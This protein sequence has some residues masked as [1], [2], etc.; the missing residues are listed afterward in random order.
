MTIRAAQLLEH[1][2]GLA[3]RVHLHDSR[4]YRTHMVPFF[5]HPAGGRSSEPKPL[6]PGNT[7]ASRSCA[8]ATAT[9]LGTWLASLSRLDAVHDW[10]RLGGG[11]RNAGGGAGPTSR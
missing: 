10:R 1:E 6:P 2:V 3:G 7:W 9:P 11:V 5:A 8:A 4:P